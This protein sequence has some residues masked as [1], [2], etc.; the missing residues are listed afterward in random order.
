MNNRSCILY[1]SYFIF[2]RLVF[3]LVAIQ[4]YYFVCGQLIFMTYL[5]LLAASYVITFSPFED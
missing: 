4:L 1:S 3:A 2:R 5:T